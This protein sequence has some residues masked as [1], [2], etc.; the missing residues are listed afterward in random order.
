M[1][2]LVND[3]S[4]MLFV[5]AYAGDRDTSDALVAFR[6]SLTRNSA[7]P[8]SNSSVDDPAPCHTEILELYSDSILSLI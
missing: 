4:A 2:E 1:N 7:T 6:R 5:Y 3:S 8:T